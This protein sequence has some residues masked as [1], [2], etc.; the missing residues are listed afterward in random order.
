MSSLTIGVMVMLLAGC[1][2][3]FAQPGDVPFTDPSP[4]TSH[5]VDVGKGVQLE[6]LV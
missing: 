5:R 2:P 6:V 4:H 1:A 3:A